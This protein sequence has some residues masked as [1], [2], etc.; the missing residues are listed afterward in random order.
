MVLVVT[1][2]AFSVSGLAARLMLSFTGKTV[3][4]V[5]PTIAESASWAVIVQ[6]PD[7]APAVK[8]ST[9][10]IPVLVVAAN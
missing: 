10:V 4:G 1:P 2:L 5:V 7:V 8:V 9:A 3:I 6:G